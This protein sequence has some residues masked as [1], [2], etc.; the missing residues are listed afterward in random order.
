MTNQEIN[1]A[2]ARKL[3]WEK[4][5]TL[6]DVTGL[7]RPNNAHWYRDGIIS[8]V[9]A[10][11]AYATDISAAWEIL[12]DRCQEWHLD[13]KGTVTATLR[14]DYEHLEAEADTAPLAICK[15]F[16]KLT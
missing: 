8:S 14:I 13:C 9:A 16:L 1:E 6:P 11:A 12:T 2:V 4:N 10:P 7:G 3:G 15:A 5:K